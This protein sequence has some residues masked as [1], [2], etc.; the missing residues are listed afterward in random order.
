M[1]KG[2][3]RR[4]CAWA[5]AAHDR[6]PSSRYLGRRIGLEQAE[7]VWSLDVSDLLTTQAWSTVG[8]QPSGTE[9]FATVSSGTSSAQ[10]AGAILQKQARVQN[11]DK[12]EALR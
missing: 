5:E 7:P 12:D 1:H 6:A 4:P 2:P 10:V 8:P 11:P 3:P 9:R